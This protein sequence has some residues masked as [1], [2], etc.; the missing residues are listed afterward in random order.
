MCSVLTHIFY[1]ALPKIYQVI[2]NLSKQLYCI[3]QI[4]KDIPI[5]QRKQRRYDNIPM[6]KYRQY[7]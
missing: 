4:A 6:E 1:V 2:S 7:Q 3:R 5:I